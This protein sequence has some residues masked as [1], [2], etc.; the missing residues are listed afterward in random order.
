MNQHDIGFEFCQDFLQ[1]LQDRAGHIGQVL[2][3]FHD[4]QV[5]VWLNG[6][7]P[8]YLIEHFTVLAGDADFRLKAFVC[9]QCQRKWSHFNGL[10]TGTKNA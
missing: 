9:R 3:G 7:Q 8:Q 6:K 1:P 10:R 2:T 5:E 4:V